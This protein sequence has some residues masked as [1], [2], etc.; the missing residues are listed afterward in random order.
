MSLDVDVA[1]ERVRVPLSRERVAALVKTVLRAERVRHALVS[2]T[3]VSRRH[4]ATLN[5]RHLD[6]RGQTD[7]IS[8]GFARSNEREPV[9]GDVYIAPEVARDNARA[10]RI[11]ARE[12][13][14][15]LVVHG[16]LHVLGYD[17][18]TGAERE[19]SAM[20]RRQERL[21]RRLAK[22]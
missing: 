8:F 1:S 17:H 21:V 9:I 5:R 6:H 13:I 10:R 4:I 14:V 18:P 19:S 2:I 16:I 15:R 20:W 3:F 12:E 22:A 7:V 11:S